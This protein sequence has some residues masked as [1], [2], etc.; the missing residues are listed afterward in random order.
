[1]YFSVVMSV[2]RNDK[3]EFVRRAVESVTTGQ[4]RKPNEVVLVVDG[5]VPEALEVLVRDYEQVTNSIFKVIWLPKNK[6]LGNALRVGVE[7]ASNEI[8][9]RMD[10]DDVSASDRFEKQISY[11]EEHPE[12]DL[13]GGQISEFIDEESNIVGKRIVP[14]EHDKILMW[15]KGRC[16]FNHMSVTMLRSRVLGVGNYMDWHFNEDY[17]LWIRMAEAG[18]R[19]ANLPDTL[20][21]VRVGADMYRR[22]G[23]WKYFKSEKGIQ[24]YMLRH[25]IISLPHYCYNVLG[26]FAVQVAMPNRLRGFIFQKLFRK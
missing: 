12:C 15:L 4:T 17:Y 7:A 23:G 19:F 8:I 14:C 26:R 22:R 10:S 18:C 3:P 16:P 5:L 6:G 21:N 11:M 13:V 20:V 2:Y 9:A 1:M 24:D 25:R